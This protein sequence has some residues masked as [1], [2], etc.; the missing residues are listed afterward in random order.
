MCAGRR[1]KSDCAKAQSDLSLRCPH[2]ETL[3]PWLSKGAPCEDSD[4]TAQV[5]LN[6]RLAH[7]SKG[8]FPDVASHTLM[9]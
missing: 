6:L 8:M 3:Y 1:L 9:R 4:Q 2:E 5:D 7:I